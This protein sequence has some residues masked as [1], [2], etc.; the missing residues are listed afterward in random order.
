MRSPVQH[1]DKRVTP[2]TLDC[3]VARQ[4]VECVYEIWRNR[5]ERIVRT[6]IRVVPCGA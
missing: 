1:S 6:A 2:L 3:V 5:F 4:M